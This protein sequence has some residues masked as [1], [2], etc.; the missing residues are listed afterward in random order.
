MSD[1][2]WCGAPVAYEAGPGETTQTVCSVS[3]VHD[4]LDDKR[5]APVEQAKRLYIAG[6]MSGLPE[7]NYP[8]FHAAEEL[9][10][11]AGYAVHNPARSGE[12]GGYLNL[13]RDDLRALL[14]C[15]GVAVLPQWE[16]SLGARNEVTVAGVIGMHV[17]PVEFWANLAN[18]DT[19]ET[20]R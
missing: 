3:A 1:A 2:C 14:D 9:L 13:L 6:P 8:A 7:L 10:T 18:T 11:R 5:P 16:H 19:N 4:P 17:N 12:L 20:T 15:D